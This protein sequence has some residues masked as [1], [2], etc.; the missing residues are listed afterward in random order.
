MTRPDLSNYT[1]ENMTVTWSV[2]F[3]GA[4]EYYVDEKISHDGGSCRWG[5]IPSKELA[6]DLIQERR[7]MFEKMLADRIPALRAVT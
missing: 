4:S 5:P 3:S 6:Y 1:T 2:L 7:A